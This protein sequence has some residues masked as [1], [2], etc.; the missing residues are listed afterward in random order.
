MR[1]N[2]FHPLTLFVACVFPL[3]PLTGCQLPVQ[4]TEQVALACLNIP[5]LLVI[6]LLRLLKVSHPPDLLTLTMEILPGFPFFLLEQDVST[7]EAQASLNHRHF[8]RVF[9]G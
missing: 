9:L 3:V 1:R 7:G 5:L 8:T 4:L 2:R 6:W